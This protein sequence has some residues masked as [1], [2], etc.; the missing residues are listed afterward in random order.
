[1]FD[2][3]GLGYPGKDASGPGKDASNKKSNDPHNPYRVEA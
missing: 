1:M 3:A 2:W